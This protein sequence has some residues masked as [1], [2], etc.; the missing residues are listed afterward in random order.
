MRTNVRMTPED[1]SSELNAKLRDRQEEV[2][3]EDREDRIYCSLSVR[4]K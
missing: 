4:V 2:D 1:V 3:T